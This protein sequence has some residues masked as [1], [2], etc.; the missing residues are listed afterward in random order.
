MAA[1]IHTINPPSQP[2]ILKVDPADRD[3]SDPNQDSNYFSEQYLED[4][5]RQLGRD[6]HSM[7]SKSALQRETESSKPSNS[8]SPDYTSTVPE[9]G[10]NQA[11]PFRF[12][13]L[14]SSPPK[15]KRNLRQ[16]EKYLNPTTS[17]ITV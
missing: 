13:K 9:N 17:Q 4:F 1:T 8:S 10:K 14:A 3:P 15:S 7:F 6:P 12:H 5:D 16:T 11:P 2:T